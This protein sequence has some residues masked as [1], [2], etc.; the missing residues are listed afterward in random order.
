M[1][2]P[3]SL[4]LVLGCAGACSPF[5]RAQ[6]AAPA[7]AATPGVAAVAAPER[8]QMSAAQILEKSRQ[9]YAAFSSYKGSCSVVRDVLIAVGD[10]APVQKVSSASAQIEFVRDKY[11]SL[12]GV[13]MGGSPFKALWTPG[14][15]YIEQVRPGAT[16]AAAGQLVRTDY[17]DKQGA[18]RERAVDSMV[19]GLTGF[20]GTAASMI[21]AALRDDFWSNPFPGPK[22][23]L[24]LL[25]ARDLGATPCYVVVATDAQLNSVNT[26]WIEQKTFLLRRLTQEQ[27]EQIFDDLPERKGV[28]EPVT[29]LAYSL[30]QLVFATTEAK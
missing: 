12:D 8:T 3:I 30:N 16:I 7:T 26:Y 22:S 2:I 6:N 10:A 14:A 5:A 9:T 20:T 15:A 17:K 18:T 29:R 4:I 1:K 21:P 24:A 23:Q 25:P 19:A 11:L 28:K 13:D 27:G